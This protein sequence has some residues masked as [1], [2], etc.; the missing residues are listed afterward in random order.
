MP[1]ETLFLDAGGVLVVPNWAR[2]SAALARRGVQVG[3]DV[4]AAA[5]P[6]AKQRL[7]LGETIQAT[8]DLQRGWL[9]F[10]LVLT[11]AGVPLDP[12]TEAALAELHEYH[13]VRNLWETVAPGVPQALAR[14]RHLGLQLVVVSN[15]NGTLHAVLDRLGLT[16]QLDV[17]IDSYR[18]GVEK[19]DPRLFQL[20]LGRARARAETTM[21][22]GDIYHIDVVGA[23]A[24]GIRA[25]LLD[26]GGIYEGYDCAR[27]RTL[28]EV[29]DL[30]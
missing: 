2:V 10:N 8:S 21:H 14:L 11:E 5:E 29:A 12:A 4:L 18:E 13:M 24:A 15:A 9:Y 22:V 26:P 6:R 25:V 27:V 28:D 23:R 16:G 30:V 7:D 19:P 20:A 1:I 17:V 3:A